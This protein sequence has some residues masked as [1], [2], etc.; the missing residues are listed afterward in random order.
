MVLRGDM[1]NSKIIVSGLEYD[2]E[3]FENTSKEFL[4]HEIELKTMSTIAL[5][6][7]EIVTVIIQLIQNIGYSAAYDVIKFSLVA[8][9][10]KVISVKKKRT[11]IEITCNGKTE[12]ISVDFELT[13]NQKDKLIDAVVMKFTAGI[14]KRNNE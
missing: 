3:E 2:N 11:T 9:T 7:A 8:I 13:E 4:E 14:E 12:A 10:N 5:V 6:G 1:M